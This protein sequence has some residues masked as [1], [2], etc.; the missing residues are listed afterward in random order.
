MI[1]ENDQNDGSATS[2]EERALAPVPVP[3]AALDATLPAGYD[4]D[5]HARTKIALKE[6]SMSAATLA[7]KAGYSSAALSQWLSG[8][9]GADVV[10]LESKIRSALDLIT[11]EKVG[12]VKT[13][14][15][16]QSRAFG[17]FARIAVQTRSIIAVVGDSGAGKTRSAA[18]YMQEN[19][20]A[21]Y[22]YVTEQTAGAAVL[23]NF[24]FAAAGIRGARGRVE[25]GALVAKKRE[26]NERLRDTDRLVI[27]DNAHR[28]SRAAIQLLMDLHDIAHLPMV[29]LGTDSLLP[30]I[31]SDV[32]W[33][34]R[35][36]YVFPLDVDTEKDKTGGW[37]ELV[38]HQAET[39]LECTAADARK[40]VT[41]A[42]GLALGEGHFR[43]VESALIL[44]RYM[45]AQMP[46][47]SMDW[48]QLFAEAAK[49][50]PPDTPG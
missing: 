38:R 4:Q 44:A 7:K 46:G 16:V 17:N 29:F 26:L 12:G 13:I 36:R 3:E 49:H 24:L 43:C 18:L 31:K 21:I 50:L 20:T 10:A 19:P 48:V 14:P 47:G 8:K 28:L 5:L 35:C 45:R 42:R 39:I 32:Q 25:G 30:K 22:Y 33:W 40:I 23:R 1:R 9:Y 41:A 34:S 37:D 2:A 27:L 6:W 11:L 15:T